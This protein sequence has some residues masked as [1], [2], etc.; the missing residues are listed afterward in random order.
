MATAN[1]IEKPDLIVCSNLI[2][3]VSKL[4]FEILFSLL[5]SSWDQLFQR[6]LVTE[7]D[8]EQEAIYLNSVIVA[9]AALETKKGIFILSSNEICKYIITLSSNIP[10]NLAETKDTRTWIGFE[11]SS[12]SPQIH[13]SLSQHTLTDTLK[14]SLQTLESAYSLTDP[15]NLSISDV[16]I[17]SSLFPLTAP[18]LL[19][20]MNAS[21]PKLLKW[22]NTVAT[23]PVVNNVLQK[24]PVVNNWL[25]V[26]QGLTGY[27]KLDTKET[28]FDKLKREKLSKPPIL[29][30]LNLDK[31][32]LLAPEIKHPILPCTDKRNILITSALPYV[33]NVPHLGNIIGCVLSADVFA[34]YC[35]ARGYQTLYLC[36]T[37]EY[38]TATEIKA[39]QEGVTP[40]QV[41]NKYYKKHKNIYDWFEI[42][43]D[44][45]G[46][47][48]TQNQTDI[49][50]E[51]FWKIQKRGFIKDET[52]EQLFCEN[53]STFLADRLITGTCPSCAYDDASGDQ[54]DN[55]SKLINAVELIQP[56]CQICKNRPFVKKSQHIF[57]DMARM[58]PEVEEWVAK[59][60]PRGNWTPNS[61]SITN[62]WFK[63][64][65]KPRCISRDLKWG[66]PVPLEGFTD[67]VFYVWFD[68]P[69]GYISI[70]A[71]YTDQWEKWW[72]NPNNVLLYQF[73]AKDNVPFHTVMFPSCLITTGDEYTLLHH[74]SASEYLNYEGGKFSKRK[75]VGVFG[76]NARETKIPADIFRFYLLYVRPETQDTLF[77]WSDLMSKNN[78]ELLNNL[79]N[80]V[81][82]SLAF[83]KKN[84]NGIVPPVGNLKQVDMQ[85]IDQINL[86]LTNYIAT[87]E[88]ARIRDGIKYTLNLS[89]LGN[90]YIQD[91]QPW[92]L[93]KEGEDGMS[94]AGTIMNLSVNLVCLV[95]VLLQPYMP[96]TCEAIRQQLNIPNNST[97]IPVEFAKFISPGH[98]IGT[99][100][101]L[102]R[103]FEQAEIDGYQQMFRTKPK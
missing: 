93:I 88:D 72:K 41:C 3:R 4:K 56:Q 51:I 16:I 61:R 17:F 70:T 6:H 29:P 101:P 89:R 64:G 18:I 48:S 47:T 69:I 10:D 40:Q 94:R 54:C 15:E 34:R 7:E 50:Q 66:T 37:D 102:F 71:S 33:N 55:C 91:A 80:F 11:A 19:V 59:S 8:I 22:V 28:K 21:Y 87:L 78:N 27:G 99:P 26:T 31:V 25:R 92:V 36:G 5:N 86:E 2:G 12:I 73:M 35:R 85:L 79:G 52:V 81:N 103:K 76:D 9:G 39:V 95:M 65:L 67:K 90:G 44:T 57:L 98:E 49:A 58:Q 38:G 43:F 32:S 60:A 20:Q 53:C 84:F 83:T 63:E 24:L 1:S 42:S 97:L 13:P 100:L 75:G 23:T 30:T 46:R 62:T 45:F 96:N 14:V 82:R 68:A 74:I 77:S